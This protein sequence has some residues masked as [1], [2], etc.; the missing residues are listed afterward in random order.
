M[1][2]LTAAIFLLAWG[3]PGWGASGW[4]SLFDGKTLN[5]WV[6]QSPHGRGYL[7]EKGLLVAPADGGG[8][9]FT[10]KE[11]ANFVFQ[12][13][14]RL[15]V[16]GNNGIGI[17]APLEGDAAWKA[18][19]IQILDDDGPEH[20]GKLRPFQYTGSIYW[21]V[22]PKT[23]HLK[24][25]GE[26]NKMEITANGRRISVKLNGTVITDAH[27]DDIRDPDI[28]KKHPGLF[29]P[30]GHIGLLGHKS[31]VEFRNLRVKELP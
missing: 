16:N 25:T 24:K 7:V 2:K 26:W 6:L 15:S 10:G 21:A 27:L 4:V 3:A 14:F 29:R 28:L 13:E 30:K 5:G 17:R 11:Y 8:N 9:L 20:Q 12:V 18:M 22:A 1:R 23:G 31:L 19:E